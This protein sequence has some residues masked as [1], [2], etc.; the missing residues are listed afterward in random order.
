MQHAVLDLI[1]VTQM[2]LI[3]N[4]VQDTGI[5]QYYHSKCGNAATVHGTYHIVLVRS[6][7]NIQVHLKKLECRGKVHLFQ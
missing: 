3:N 6:Y 5:A 2:F 7:M 4:M 1:A